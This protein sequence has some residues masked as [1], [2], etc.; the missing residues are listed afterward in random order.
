MMRIDTE[1]NDD[2]G[3]LGIPGLEYHR[4]H[5]TQ[6]TRG[7]LVKFVGP[8]LPRKRLGRKT[9]VPIYSESLSKSSVYIVAIYQIPECTAINAINAMRYRP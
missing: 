1:D 9:L 8:I 3:G 4:A 2:R 6:R 7:I 5:I